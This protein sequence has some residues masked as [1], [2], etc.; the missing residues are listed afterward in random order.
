M[1]RMINTHKAAARNDVIATVVKSLNDI[2][3]EFLDTKLLHK[4]NTCVNTTCIAMEN[5]LFTRQ[6]YETRHATL[7]DGSN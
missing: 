2:I 4:R 1:L 5:Y 3:L 6:S 7:N